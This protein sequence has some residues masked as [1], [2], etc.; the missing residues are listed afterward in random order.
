M[1]VNKQDFAKKMDFVFNLK[2]KTI[3]N[4]LYDCSIKIF[5][6]KI[7]GNP[8]V[9]KTY[10]SLDFI[11]LKDKYKQFSDDKIK[12]LLI[13]SYIMCVAIGEYKIEQ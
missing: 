1:N 12:Q 10:D 5:Q 8:Y 2:D 4:D 9:K 7:K 3:Y 11:I 6:Q 13:S